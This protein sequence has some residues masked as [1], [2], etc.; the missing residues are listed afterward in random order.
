LALARARAWWGPQ[1]TSIYDGSSASAL[2]SGLM[3]GA[4]YE[5]C[6]Q[7]SY[8]GMALEYGTVPMMEVI[9]AL[10]ADQWLDQHPEA[11]AAQHGAIK[12]RLRDAFYPDTPEWQQAVLDQ[13]RE[14]TLQ[15]VAGLGA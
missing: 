5:E 7:A 13:A 4:A 6:P 10:R 9:D 1:V 14:A 2:L 11:G 15:G 3:W 8:T 12:R